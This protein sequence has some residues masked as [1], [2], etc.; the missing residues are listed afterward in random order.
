MAV[1]TGYLAI[2]AK[3]QAASGAASPSLEGVADFAAALLQATS[4]AA[5]ALTDTLPVE[6]T[7]AALAGVVS[8]SFGA[9][10]FNRIHLLP[11]TLALGNVLSSQV[12]SLEVFSSYFEARELQT[13]A[14]A[15]ASPD[16]VQL[17][18]PGA[19]PLAFAPLQS[20]TWSV[21]VAGS[22]PPDIAATATFT[23][24]VG[25]RAVVITGSRIVVFALG[26]DWSEDFI[27]AF[28]WL[29]DVMRSRNATEQ[30]VQLR[31][32]P[33]RSWEFRVLALEAA[34]QAHLQALLWAWQ[35]RFFAVPFW[36]DALGV[37]EMAAGTTA[38]PLDLAGYDFDDG[39]LA[40]LWQDWRTWEAVQI[41]SVQPTGLVLV[42]GTQR[43]WPAGT[44]CVPLRNAAV[45][46]SLEV[47]QLVPSAAATRLRFTLAANE[48]STNRI[49]V[50]SP[51]QYRGLD[52]WLE[53]PDESEA[54]SIEVARELALID[55]STGIFELDSRSYGAEPGREVRHWFEG[56]DSISAF[57]GWLR[58]RAG[59][60]VPVWAP[61]RR[62]DFELAGPVG[63]GA[64]TIT[65]VWTGYSSFYHLA[66]SRRDLAFLK[67][68]GSW[69]FRRITA[70][71]DLGDSEQLTLDSALGAE[72]AE[73]E[74][75]E[76]ICFL[77]LCR[78]DADQVELVWRTNDFA[79]SSFR[80]RGLLYS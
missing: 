9:L 77:E 4:P 35:D 33:R 66:G 10:W 5:G 14:L 43:A 19:L 6:M 2:G 20:R 67:A 58:R 56:H 61:T 17:T 18:A 24:D 65:V 26:P 72:V 48:V 11:G 3:L 62:A 44:V 76:L 50:V 64:T 27:E 53:E 7:S 21:S 40:L 79:L 42:R 15:G 22:G 30:R 1:L 47:N 69:L 8:G 74:D 55:G 36:P 68:D 25:P 54:G 16:G 57:L 46:P 29:T 63:P 80:F 37:D 31:L 78:L 28:V 32:V 45:Q 52:V 71:E 38:I 59:R 13:V 60:A 49:A 70:A 34:E 39:G 41:D 51:T 23:F 73:P 12:L 75:F